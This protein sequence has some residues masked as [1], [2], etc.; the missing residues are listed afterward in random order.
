MLPNSIIREIT[1]NPMLPLTDS[2]LDAFKV[3]VHALAILCVGVTSRLQVFGFM[4]VSVEGELKESVVELKNLLNDPLTTRMKKKET[5]SIFQEHKKSRP[6]SALLDSRM[7]SVL[8]AGMCAW[9]L[10]GR[11]T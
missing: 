4:H 5:R 10:R 1:V 11:P 9:V 7:L 6:V 8:I 2:Q 3:R